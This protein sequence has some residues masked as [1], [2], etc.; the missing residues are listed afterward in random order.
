MGEIL[1]PEENL[2]IRSFLLPSHIAHV[3][4]TGGYNQIHMRMIIEV[5]LMGMQHSMGRRCGLAI[6]DHGGQSCRS[7]ARRF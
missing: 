3:D 4:G 1:R 6:E 2:F 7:S 5:A